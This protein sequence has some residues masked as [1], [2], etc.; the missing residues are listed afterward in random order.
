[1]CQISYHPDATLS[2][3]M[4][5]WSIRFIERKISVGISEKWGTCSLQKNDDHKM[6]G[7]KDLSWSHGGFHDILDEIQGFRELLKINIS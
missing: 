5:I 7:W 6:E 4:K 3:L 1:M 2:I